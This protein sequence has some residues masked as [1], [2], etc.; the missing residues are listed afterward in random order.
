MAGGNCP[1]STGS[2]GADGNRCG[3]AEV[4]AIELRE[5]LHP[6]IASPASMM[7]T[8]DFNLI[9][10][11]LNLLVSRVAAAKAALGHLF[12]GIMTGVSRS[13]IG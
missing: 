7:Q 13:S 11:P 1:A 3:S 12:A 2:T 5:R 9:V 8:A 4:G 10:S 6:A